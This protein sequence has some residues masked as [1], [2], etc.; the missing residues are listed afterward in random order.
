MQGYSIWNADPLCPG[1]HQPEKNIIQGLLRHIN[2]IARLMPEMAK[3]LAWDAQ[4]P[5]LSE[6][7][8]FLRQMM[9]ADFVVRFAALA[10]SE[11][12]TGEAGV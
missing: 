5:E 6:M 3:E 12:A 9:S 2:Y 8:H 11:P 1:T 4:R 10:L 7:L